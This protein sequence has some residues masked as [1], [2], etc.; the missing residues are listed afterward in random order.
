MRMMGGIRDSRNQERAQQ[1]VIFSMGRKSREEERERKGE[2]R[3]NGMIAW[4][5][6]QQANKQ[7]ANERMNDPTE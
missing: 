3:G 4:S 6:A 7:N 2:K 1:N 5:K